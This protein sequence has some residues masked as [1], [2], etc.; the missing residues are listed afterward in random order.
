MAA[1]RADHFSVRRAA[2]GLTGALMA[3]VAAP[4]AGAA[5]GDWYATVV[6]VGGAAEVTRLDIDGM[7][8]PYVESGWQAVGGG[9]L[10]IGRT[11]RA[12][13]IRTELEVVHRY[14]FDLD[15]RSPSPEGLLDFET[16]IGTTSAMLN[17]WV[18]HRGD[19]PVTPF[20]GATAG[21]A[22]HHVET[23]R[24]VLATGKRA[25]EHE[26]TDVFAWGLGAGAS[27]DF[28]DR[29]TAEAVWRYMNLGEVSTGTLETG[30][31][32]EAGAYSSHDLVLGLR[33]RFR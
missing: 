6:I 25:D 31:S 18:E 26:A 30:E 28:A 9:G 24:T 20:I 29:W 4:P 13:P 17:L 8:A 3:A 27:W 21:W 23:I 14:R 11:W 15:V 5:G 2:F 1:E 10:R 32:Y 7:D 16:N 22:R 19:G 12:L 33:Y